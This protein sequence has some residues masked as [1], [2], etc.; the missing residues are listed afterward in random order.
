VSGMNAWVATIRP[1]A[2]ATLNRLTVQAIS[3][4]PRRQ[5]T[6]RPRSRKKSSAA[7]AKAVS[8]RVSRWRLNC[9]MKVPLT[10]Y[11]S[12]ATLMIM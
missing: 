3:H 1:T 4:S 11:P 6:A 10:P 5:A 12:N 8:K 9:A 2:V 7:A